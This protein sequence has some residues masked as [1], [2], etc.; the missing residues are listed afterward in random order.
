MLLMLDLS[1]SLL[2]TALLSIARVSVNQMALSTFRSSYTY[3]INEAGRIS[4]PSKFR[5]ILRNVFN[6]DDVTIVP[7]KLCL[8]VFP[9]QVW[10]E[11][12]AQYQSPSNPTLM[13]HK[14]KLFAE[15]TDL[16]IDK[17]GRI[18]IPND[19][20][21]QLELSDECTLV[22]FGDHFEIWNSSKW[23][24]YMNEVDETEEDSSSM[25]DEF[26]L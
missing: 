2:F 9:M 15:A 11:R 12:V 10:E 21:K 14:R 17:Q 3:K 5:D 25:F 22:G 6:S 8:K 23:N 4:V 26:N 20:R 1:A 19:I 24:E 13:K 7:A 16:E 18:L